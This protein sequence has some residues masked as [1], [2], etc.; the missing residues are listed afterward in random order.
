MN[1]AEMAIYYIESMG[2]DLATLSKDWCDRNKKQQIQ[3]QKYIL[4]NVYI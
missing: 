1:S 2:F 4:E 3:K